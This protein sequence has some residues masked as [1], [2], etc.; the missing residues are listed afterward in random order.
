MNKLNY[1]KIIALFAFIIL[2]G[3]SCFWTAE[4]LFIWQPSITI[5]G[6]WA[7]AI[8][9]DII[10]S[11]CFGKMLKALDKNEDF[12]GKLGGRTG[13][14]LIG[15]LGLVLFWGASFATNTHTLL[16]RASIE[17]VII[18]DLNRTQGYLSD[19]RNN[20]VEIKKIEQKYQAKEDEVEALLKRLIAECTDPSNPGIGIRFNKILAE[21]DIVLGKKIQRVKDNGRTRTQLL[22]TI[23]HYAQQAREMLKVEKAKR[24]NEIAQLKKVM[25]STV[26]ANLMANNKIALSDIQNM[27]GINHDII[28][29]AVLDL[30]NS[31]SYIK[32]NSKYIEF[33]EQDKEKYTKDGAIPEAQKMLAINVVWKDFLSTDKYDAH[34]FA[35]W[36]VIALMID[37]AAFIF[38]NKVF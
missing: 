32:S 7:F 10:A 26:L 11:I 24:N 27:E 2:A 33:K 3:F 9:F 5:Y 1:S 23:E 22:I 8:C 18:D 31:Y 6:A 34:G 28:A 14:L 19:L 37:L 29:A 35:W 38:F 15:L 16:Y 20:N 36:I 25:N 30:E 17:S 12:Y 21:L 13:A 4:S